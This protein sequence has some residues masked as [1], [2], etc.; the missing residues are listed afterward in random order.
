MYVC[1]CNKVT[2]KEIH[3]ACD[4][5]AK[6]MSCLEEKLKV[7]TCCGRCKDCAQKLLHENLAMQFNQSQQPALAT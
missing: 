6:S 5:G 7:A 1:V 4:D 2:D 3:Q